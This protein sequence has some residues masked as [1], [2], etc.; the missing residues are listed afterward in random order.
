MILFIFSLFLRYS[1]LRS[2]FFLQLYLY[3]INKMV[4]YIVKLSYFKDGFKSIVLNFQKNHE[5][6]IITN[7]TL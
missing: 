2:Y 4:N 3:I 1:C 6:K 7:Q 5:F